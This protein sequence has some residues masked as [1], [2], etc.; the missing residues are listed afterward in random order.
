[1]RRRRAARTPLGSAMAG[2]PPVRFLLCS[3]WLRRLCPSYGEP[4]MERMA[5]T[6]PAL[7]VTATEVFRPNSYGDPAPPSAMHSTSGACTAC[8]LSLESRCRA[9][10]RCAVSM[11]IFSTPVI[12]P[13]YRFARRGSPGPV[14]CAACQPR[15][16]PG[17]PS[18]TRG[19][20]A[21]LERAKADRPC[22]SG[23]T[24]SAGN[25]R[26]LAA[27]G[28]VQR[29]R[30]M[31]PAAHR[32]GSRGSPD[33]LPG[34]ADRYRSADRRRADPPLQSEG[35][36]RVSRG[37]RSPGP[38]RAREQPHPRRRGGARVRARP[39]RLSESGG[40]ASRRERTPLRPARRATGSRAPARR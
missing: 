36:P 30:R 11:R 20:A 15:K 9:R 34:R 27:G 24:A 25:S 35:G 23:W 2:L 7:A 3:S 37:R 4:G 1:M 18:A 5:A 12:C 14:L 17:M 8:S 40:G 22:R 39:P 10:R 16:M 38:L 33:G 32:P 13:A 6:A 29:R 26:A 31:P 28:I 19:E 21:S